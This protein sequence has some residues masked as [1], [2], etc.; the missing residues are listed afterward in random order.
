[1]AGK[2]LRL[3]QLHPGAIDWI[4]AGRQEI[5]RQIEEYIDRVREQSGKRLRYAFPLETSCVMDILTGLGYAAGRDCLD[6][7]VR[8]SRMQLPPKNGRFLAWGIENIVD[9]GMQLE[10]RR[11]WKV[12]FRDEQKSYWEL[13]VE[14]ELSDVHYDTAQDSGGEQA[15]DADQMLDVA[16]DP[17]SIDER[18]E[19]GNSFADQLREADAVVD[20]LLNQTVDEPSSSHR[21]AL[22]SDVPSRAMRGAAGGT[23][24]GRPRVGSNVS[25]RTASVPDEN[26]TFPRRHRHM[27]GD[28]G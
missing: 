17:G 5:R 1:M 13:E 4:D 8:H 12:G 15:P 18:A 2:A 16:I 19:T 28:I 14:L 7:A 27:E 21:K 6:Y 26:R 9:L 20:A 3:E 10:R 25:A 24:A 23:R 22:D 11:R